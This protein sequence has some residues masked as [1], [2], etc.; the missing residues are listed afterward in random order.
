MKKVRKE[1]CPNAFLCLFSCLFLFFTLDLA[2]TSETTSS[3]NL[4]NKIFVTAFYVKAVLF[5][6]MNLWIAL[7]CTSN[8][9]LLLDPNFNEV[10]WRKVM[11]L[12]NLFIFVLFNIAIKDGWAGIFWICG[13]K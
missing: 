12:T 10:S 6:G 5:Y 4:S 7:R 13:F 2:V 3:Q 8:P 1:I 11:F 9:K